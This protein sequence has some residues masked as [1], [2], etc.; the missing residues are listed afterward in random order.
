MKKTLLINFVLDETGSMLSVKDATISGFN[1]YLNTLKG[2]KETILFT[3][4]QFNS[5]K[6]E[7]V[8]DAVSLDNVPE[9]THETYL[10]DACT[11]LYDA[12]ARTIRATENRVGGMKGKPSVLCVVQTDG[13][14]NASQEYGL[15][16]IRKLITEKTDA[17][18]TFAYLGAGQ[19]A[20]A[21]GASIGV[22][23][24]S[25]LS[26]DS[27]PAS[28]KQAFGVTA[29]ATMAYARSGGTQTAAFYGEPKDIRKRRKPQTSASRRR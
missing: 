26:Y 16:Q 21:V 7:V 11:P 24:A 28:T 23:T 2:R 15:E 5:E 13:L 9:L 3:L 6:V 10:P 22:P 20:W 4:T 19:D 14:E 18:W 8:H 29:T 27:T 25:T 12:V 1:E 17:G